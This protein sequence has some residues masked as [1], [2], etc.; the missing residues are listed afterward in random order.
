[1]TGVNIYKTYEAF[2]SA[3]SLSILLC[4]ASLRAGDPCIRSTYIDLPWL[5]V[6][7]MATFFSM[8][9]EVITGN[10]GGNHTGGHDLGWTRSDNTSV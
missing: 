5:Y 9:S 10:T 7:Y 2:G 6:F 1:M 8:A 3:L 4:F